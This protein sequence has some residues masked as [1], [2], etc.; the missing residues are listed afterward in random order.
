MKNVML[1]GPDG[2]G[3]S[4]IANELLIRFA[5]AGNDVEHVWLRF[6]HFT[7][8]LVNLMGRITGKS[9][10]EK[11]QW[12][13]LGYHNYGG[14]IGLFYI[15]AVYI[16][17]LIF[18]CLVRKKYFKK[19]KLYIID[20]YIIDVMA[21]LI[22]DTKRND[23]IFVLFSHWLKKELNCSNAFILRCDSENVVHRRKD[24]VDDKKYSAKVE[25]YKII[26]SRFQI[27][28][29]DSGFLSIDESVEKIQNSLK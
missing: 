15:V 24:I 4:T 13:R 2:T 7:A 27:A 6:N 25:A 28:T 9:Y 11:Y 14:I 10:Y 26:A 1:S 12:G 29:I 21:D 5:E 19:N 17:H 22:V 16:D 23:L 3:K 18:T 20:R 8:K